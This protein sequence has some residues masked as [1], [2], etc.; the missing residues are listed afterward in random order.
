VLGQKKGVFL[1]GQMLKHVAG[2]NRGD[3]LTGRVLERKK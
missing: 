1:T 2:Q 3:I